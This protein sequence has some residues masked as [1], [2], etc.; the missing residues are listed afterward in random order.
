MSQTSIPLVD[1]SIQVQEIWDDFQ[2]DFF[3]LCESGGFIGGKTVSSFESQF[4]QFMNVDHCIG[5]GNGGD[6]IELALRAINVSFGDEVLIPANTFIATATAVSRVGAIPIPV[7]VNE[8][9][10][11]IDVS[12]IEKLVS[13]R[14]KAI[15]PVHL[16]GQMADM[17]SVLTIASR[18]KISV[19]EDAA[20]S[21]GA[22]QNGSSCGT[23]GAA[24]AT[25][26]YPGKNLGAFG[27][28]GAVLTGDLEIDK[29]IRMLRN[30]GGIKKYEHE[31]VGFN[32]R[33]DAIQAL[34]LTHKLKHLHRWNT[35]RQNAAEI[36]TTILE[37]TP[38]IHLPKANPGN[39]H[40]WHLYVV[41]VP[42]RDKVIAALNQLGI[43]AGIHY[44]KPFHELPAYSRNASLYSECTAAIKLSHEILSLPIYPGITES[45]IKHVCQSLQQSLELN[46]CN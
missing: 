7:D 32:S 8:S 10:F 40:V 23:F 22:T 43:G 37:G 3:K 25:S 36:Y 33:L 17:S 1:L 28:G 13:P 45:Q 4:A 5:V 29:R 42:Q 6:A 46:D 26:F 16:F 21:Q 24:T 14:T 44:P 34:V 11:L 30:Y 31:T 39:T 20:Q 18:L 19:I 41:R 27:D 2:A 15:I 35:E 9:D 12:K 38:N